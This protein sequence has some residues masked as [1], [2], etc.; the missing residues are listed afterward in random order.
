MPFPVLSKQAA[1]LRVTLWSKGWG[2]CHRRLTHSKEQLPFH[3]KQGQSF[4]TSLSQQAHDTEQTQALCSHPIITILRIQLNMEGTACTCITMPATLL[5]CSFLM[6]TSVY[7]A[8]KTTTVNET[9]SLDL[10]VREKTGFMLLVWWWDGSEMERLFSEFFAHRQ[11]LLKNR[12]SVESGD[13]RIYWQ[14]Q[15]SMTNLPMNINSGLW[16]GYNTCVF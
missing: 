9:T 3:H 7:S 2:S 4:T 14:Q 5:H 12:N 13:A 15:G 16:V 10:M 6:P 1:R 8:K 11:T